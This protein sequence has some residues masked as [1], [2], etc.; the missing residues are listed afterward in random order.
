MINGMATIMLAL[1]IDPK[2]GLLTDQVMREDRSNG[3][4][5]LSPACQQEIWEAIDF[6]PSAKASIWGQ[7]TP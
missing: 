6:S 7:E 3:E 2:I 4:M 5:R 1:L